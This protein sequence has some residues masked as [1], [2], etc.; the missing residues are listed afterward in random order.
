MVVLEA[1]VCCAVELLCIIQRGVSVIWHS[2]IDVNGIDKI[3]I[4]QYV[5]A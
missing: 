2:L 3:Y 1:V 5:Y 4:S